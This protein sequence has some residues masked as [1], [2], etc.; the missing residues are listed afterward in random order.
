VPGRDPV[1]VISH[2]LWVT[3]FAS[4]P[5]VVGQSIS[6]NGLPFKVVGVAPEAFTGPNAWLRADLYVPPPGDAAGAGWR[7]RAE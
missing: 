3:E 4:S 5:D 7:V 6:L 2:V 1:V